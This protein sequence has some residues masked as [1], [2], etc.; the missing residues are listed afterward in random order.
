[1]APRE[2]RSLEGNLDCGTDGQDFFTMNLTNPTV[3]KVKVKTCEHGDEPCQGNPTLPDAFTACGGPDDRVE[4]HT[5]KTI[6]FT[7]NTTYIVFSN[8][9]GTKEFD[10]PEVCLIYQTEPICCHQ[11][12]LK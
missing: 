6:T 8:G 12:Q 2:E 7:R 9:V 5:S 4:G 10:R 11:R 3:I 1:M